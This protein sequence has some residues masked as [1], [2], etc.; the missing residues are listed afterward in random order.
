MPRW[1]RPLL[2]IVFAVCLAYVFGKLWFE[3]EADQLH[4]ELAIFIGALILVIVTA[5]VSAVLQ[6]R[7]RKLGDEQ[8]MLRL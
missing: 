2:T 5:A 4:P 7:R 8:S 6:R 3:P 1:V